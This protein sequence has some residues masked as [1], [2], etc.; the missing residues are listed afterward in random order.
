MPGI[1]NKVDHIRSDKKDMPHPGLNNSKVLD[2]RCE[3]SDCHHKEIDIN[4]VVMDASG[5]VIRS[6]L[7]LATDEIL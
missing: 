4:F 2:M 3:D 1:S 6:E 5:K 7:E